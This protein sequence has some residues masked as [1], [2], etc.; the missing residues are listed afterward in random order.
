M[1]STE[2]TKIRDQIVLSAL[3][4][5]YQNR[6]VV[7]TTYVQP[8][9]FE[10]AHEIFESNGNNV[11]L[12][13]KSTASE[14]ALDA[15]KA[16]N[17]V[18]VVNCTIRVPCLHKKDFKYCK[19][20]VHDQPA[21]DILRYLE[22]AATFLHTMLQEGSLLVHCEHGVSRSATVV[23]AYL[24]RF[25]GMSRDEAYVRCKTKRPRVNPNTGFWDQLG[26]YEQMVQAAETQKLSPAQDSIAEMD[27]LKWIEMTQAFFVTCRELPGVLATNPCWDLMLDKV[28]TSPTSLRKFLVTC[29]DFIWG[30]GLQDVDLEWFYFTLDAFP[31]AAGDTRPES[32]RKI[33]Q[34]L[35][36]DPESELREAWSGEVYQWQ[37]E[38]ATKALLKHP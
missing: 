23:M 16:A 20:N 17:I 7:E 22:G 32:P 33:V 11:Y 24:I 35:L 14:D 38:K 37:I 26:T 9:L 5:Q 29:L 30:R 10:Y 4:L 13:P 15:L 25:H 34:D 12:G 19:V 27:V 31:T 3:G 2:R 36:Q 1:E 18:A 8:T 6:P 28:D 21:A